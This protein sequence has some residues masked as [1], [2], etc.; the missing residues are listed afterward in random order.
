MRYECIYKTTVPPIEGI[1]Y[2]KCRHLYEIVSPKTKAY[3]MVWVEEYLDDFFAL[4]FH[5]RK[6]K[7]NSKKY[8]I[9]SGYH[10]ARPIILTCIDLLV[11]IANN[12]P[13]ASFGFIGAGMVDD[14]NLSNT[15][16]YRVYK[17]FVST[18]VS[19]DQFEH[20]FLP[21]K[22]AYVLLRKSSISRNP[23]IKK[24]LNKKFSQMYS[25]FE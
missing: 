8:S 9:L 16:R 4:K 10:E 22:S 15:K 12:C 17:R 2:M 21:Q 3:Y 6:D 7:K 1:V 13:N 11:K 19:E 14:E 20:L 18:F 24:E 25:H 23:N 5:L